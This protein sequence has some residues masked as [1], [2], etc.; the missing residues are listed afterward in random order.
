[1]STK[2][3]NH[4]SVSFNKNLSPGEIQ[5]IEEYLDDHHKGWKIS[6]LKT[7]ITGLSFSGDY[8]GGG[9]KA[10][11]PEPPA[12]GRYVAIAMQEEDLEAVSKFCPHCK[13]EDAEGK[14][15]GLV[16]FGDP[17]GGGYT[18]PCI[19]PVGQHVMN[20]YKP[21]CWKEERTKSGIRDQVLQLVKRNL[22]GFAY[23]HSKCDERIDAM[24]DIQKQRKGRS[25][26]DMKMSTADMDKDELPF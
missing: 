10:N 23:S 8:G 14:P 11:K 3:S 16:S 2:W 22:S 17:D 4:Y 21:W 15:T 26:S 25:F 5:A 19:C 13:S 12:I 24:P 7:A 18:L 6:H 20:N 9:N 1:M